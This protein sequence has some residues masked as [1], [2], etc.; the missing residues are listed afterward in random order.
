MRLPSATKVPAQTRFS[1]VSFRT[2]SWLFS[3]STASVST[4]FGARAEACSSRSTVRARGSS[5]VGSEDVAA[6][7]HDPPLW[8]ESKV[9]VRTSRKPHGR[10]WHRWTGEDRFHPLIVLGGVH[11]RLR[12]SRRTDSACLEEETRRPCGCPGAL[13]SRRPHSAREYVRRRANDPA[14]CPERAFRNDPGGD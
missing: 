3:T 6:A 4:A 11:R 1:S 12:C 13:R 9:S 7:P 14:V 5:P 10:L 2:T 8:G